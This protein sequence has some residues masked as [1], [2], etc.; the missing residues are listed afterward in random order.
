MPYFQQ[1]TRLNEQKKIQITT[2]PSLYIFYTYPYPDSSQINKLDYRGRPGEV[3][4]SKK[5]TSKQ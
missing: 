3:K 4:Y 2:I 5:K 1:N